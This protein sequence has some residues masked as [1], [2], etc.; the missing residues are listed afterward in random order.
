MASL[1]GIVHS[2]IYKIHTHKS[3]AILNLYFMKKFDQGRLVH[4][5]DGV[6]NKANASIIVAL[7][8]FLF[9]I[10]QHKERKL[11]SGL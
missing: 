10:V 7:F 3:L 4:R 8:N 5:C 9:Q 11:K 1:S 6:V 2:K